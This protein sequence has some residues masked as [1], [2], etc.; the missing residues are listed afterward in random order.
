MHDE[1]FETVDWSTIPGP[2][3]Y[4]P[5]NVLAALRSMLSPNAAGWA[6]PATMMRFAAGNDH[7]GT[8]YPAA[9]AA[10]TAMLEITDRHP[11]PPR[12]AALDVLLDWWVFDPEPGYD[13]Y[14]DNNGNAVNM[15]QAI[16][17]TVLA[18]SPVLQRVAA[19]PRDP[20]AAR[21][22]RDLLLCARHGWG[23]FL[24]R[25][26]AVTQPMCSTYG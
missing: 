6:H 22:A 20:V 4:R 5:D 12:Q 17:N 1:P 8:I 23:S 11:G 26:F 2:P 13:E 24:S 16:Q 14:V 9:V 18:A 15:V 25:V 19:D 21:G 7:G 3:D 10:T